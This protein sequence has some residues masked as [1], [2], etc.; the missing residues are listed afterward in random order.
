MFKA[1]FGT[2]FNGSLVF[3]QVIQYF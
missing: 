3:Q 2:E 1:R